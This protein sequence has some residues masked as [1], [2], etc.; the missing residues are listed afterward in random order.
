MAEVT[1]FLANWEILP[2]IIFDFYNYQ[3]S[4]QEVHLAT[5]LVKPKNV[6]N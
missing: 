4:E 6:T 5:K 2:D 3:R 1:K